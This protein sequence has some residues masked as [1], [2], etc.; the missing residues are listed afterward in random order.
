MDLAAQDKLDYNM[1]AVDH[2]ASLQPR[3]LVFIS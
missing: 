2:V 3:K 1:K